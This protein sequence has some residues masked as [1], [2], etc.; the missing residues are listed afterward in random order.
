VSLPHF[1]AG[2]PEPG[3]TVALSPDD[4]R[5]AIRSLRLKPGDM[6]TSA[7]GEGGVA[8]ARIVRADRLLVE[9][10]VVERRLEE[11]QTPHLSVL[12]APPKGDRLTWAIQKLTEVGV[13]EITLLETSRTVRRFKGERA[14]R[15]SV[16][17]DA[18]AREA[19]KQSERAFLPTIG[20]PVPWEEAVVPGE[21]PFFVMWE[22]GTQGLLSLLPEERP[23]RISLVIGPEGG[24]PEED[25]RAAEAAGAKLAWL[26]PTILKVETAALAAASI[27]LARYGRLG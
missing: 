2:A 25:A 17:L 11:R 5:H 4:A 9:A 16:R 14:G 24:I 13:D 15:I 21:D 8:T 22:E 1:F 23:E 26:G 12:M 6:L 20:G 18:V 19:A 10:E 7:D 27:A 3:E